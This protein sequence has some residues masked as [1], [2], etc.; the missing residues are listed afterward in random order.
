MFKFVRDHWP[1]CEIRIKAALA[2]DPKWNSCDYEDL[3]KLAF[4]KMFN[5]GKVILDLTQITTID[6]GAYQGTQLY[7]IP[8]DTYQPSPEDYIMTHQYY[9]SCSGCDTLQAI[10]DWGNKPLTEEQIKNYTS[11][12]R[13][14]LVNAIKPY[15]GGWRNQDMFDLVEEEKKDA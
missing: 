7:L 5:H 14:L 9:G 6:N 10:Q 2:E 8:F 1:E 4:D 13:D 15:N 3:V 12:C 11:L